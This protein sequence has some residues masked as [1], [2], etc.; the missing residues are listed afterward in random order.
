MALTASEEIALR[1][2]FMEIKRERRLALQRMFEGTQ[3]KP[4]SLLDDAK[5]MAKEANKARKAVQKVPGLNAP[6]IDLPSLNIALFKGIDLRKLVDIDLPSLS[7]PGWD[8]S[9]VPNFRLGDFP[10]FSLPKVRIN[11][12]GII[13][14]KDLLPDIRLPAIVWAIGVKFPHLTLP[15]VLWDLQNIFGIDLMLNLSFPEFT[16]PDLSVTL[17]NVSLPDMSLPHV[18]VPSIDLDFPTIDLS[19]VEIPGINLDLYLKIPGFDKVLKLLFE[20]FDAVDLPDILAELGTEFLTDFISS[21]LPIV[22]QVKSGGKAI[23]EWGKAAQDLHKASKV[24][25][26]IP[27]ILPG[28]A[29]D[30]CMAVQRLLKESSAEHAGLAT[31]HTAQFAVST[32][33]LFTDL[34]GATGPATAAVA[35]CARTCQKVTIFAMKYKEMKKINAIL[36]DNPGHTLTSNIFEVSPLLGCYYIA[37]NTT[38]NVLNILCENILMDNWMMDAE[39]NKRKHLDPLIKESQRFIDKSRYVLS[40]IRQNKGMYVERGYFEK[41]K[42]AASLYFKKKFGIAPKDAKVS[43]HRYIG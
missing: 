3:L 9:L 12:K 14:Y 26:H 21:A 20:L 16:V 5:D 30:A 18:N 17:P 13:K 37:N 38:S 7:I 32:A 19:M 40:P 23:S 35:A 2:A 27:F 15:S 33:G 29:R 34:G 28:N 1:A 8:L 41:K 11:L 6:D 39:N 42:E 36:R 4:K 22:Q 24:K 43:S 10:G 31:T 25:K